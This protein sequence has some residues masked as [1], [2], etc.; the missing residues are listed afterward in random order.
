MT[1]DGYGRIILQRSCLAWPAPLFDA[2]ATSLDITMH[3]VTHSSQ[4][5]PSTPLDAQI[6][7]SQP[8]TA[9]STCNATHALHKYG[10]QAEKVTDD[11]IEP[12]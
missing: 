6:T 8:R 11:G 1:C 10:L 12:P 5:L 9:A 7:I 4:P 3:A 2:N